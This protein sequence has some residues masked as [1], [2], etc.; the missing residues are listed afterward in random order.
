MWQRFWGVPNQGQLAIERI[1]P[2]DPQTNMMWHNPRNRCAR[3]FWN[4]TDMDALT[5]EM[6]LVLGILAGAILLFVT[7]IVRIDVAAIIVMV[8]V[9]LTGLVGPKELFAGFA[10]NAVI[11]I[12]AVMIL[13]A[14]LDRVGVMKKVAAFLL[15]IGGTGEGRII[16]LISS[17]VAGISAFMQNI[18]AAALFLPVTER[19]AERTGIPVSRMLMPMGFAAILGGTITLVA[20][21]P[22]ILLNDLL[23]AS[24]KNLGVEIEPLGLFTPTPIGLALSASGIA[25]FAIFG[26][27]LLPSNQKSDSTQDKTNLQHLYGIQD[28]I[29]P[30]KVEATSA[31]VGKSVGEIEADVH[32]VFLV[33]AFS[34][35]NGLELAL[36]MEFII[37][38][39]M[40]LGLVGDD[41]DL[42]RFAQESALK[43]HSENPFKLFH[44]PE[45]AGIAELVIRPGA[46][47]LGKTVR[48]LRLRKRYGVTLLCIHRQ[49]ESVRDD[50][51]N[52]VLQ[53]GDVLVV[54]APWEQLS[55]LAERR[56]LVIISDVPDETSKPEKTWW[57]LAAF[58]IALA[59]VI[60][61][62]LKLSLALMV[63]VVIILVSKTLSPDE[64]YRSVSWKTVFL[65]AA[66][67]PLGQAV[68]TTGT[69]QW[70][71]QG[72]IS[73]AGDLPIWGMQLT[74]AL[75]ATVFS[76][77]ISNVGA[78]VLLVPLA[79]NVAV[80]I[81][82]N[83]AQFGLIV[84]IAVSNA[85][86]LPTHQVNALLMGPGNYRVK[87]FLKAGT[88][89]SVLFLV[90]LVVSVNIFF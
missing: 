62:T 39:D 65:L 30:W 11:S 32:G 79:A 44:D 78:T 25:L 31:L 88:T 66:L 84:A 89:L 81:G 38:A 9:G 42:A 87:D 20:S 6:M 23:A 53:G 63:G 83:P 61:G 52:E 45:R 19:M 67:I 76:L 4:E 33:A 71:A 54:F 12:I 28:Q 72:V 80:G 56:D 85:F 77:T 74:I 58:A 68:E 21:G 2:R 10:S 55:V 60:S 13:G 49:G 59:L 26:K 48:D 18:G 27:W 51:R 17:S 29:E 36:P 3:L 5:F 73:A 90:V 75:L 47:A 15:K 16:T 57:A 70:I 46:D 24:S 8:V 1:E 40:V 86:L 69:A 82:A 14:A 41:E 43:P 37:K 22:L 50:L 7:E 64:A 35:E 34:E